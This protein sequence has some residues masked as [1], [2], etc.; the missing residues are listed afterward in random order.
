[1]YWL[2]F[3]CRLL[4]YFGSEGL[5]VNVRHR[6]E[7]RRLLALMGEQVYQIILADGRTWT[8]GAM[9]GAE[10]WLSALASVMK[11]PSF[12]DTG[13]ADLIF[14]LPPEGHQIGKEPPKWGPGGPLDKCSCE[15]SSRVCPGVVFYS[16][17]DAPH[18]VCCLTNGHGPRFP[19]EQM[20]RSLLPIF[21]GEL[22][23][24]SI[25]LHAALVEHDGKAVLLAGKSG[26]GKSTCCRRLPQGWEVLSDDMALVLRTSESYKAHP[27][28]TWS[29]VEDF[30]GRQSWSINRHVV[31]SAIFFLDQADRDEMFPLGRGEATLGIYD[32]SSICFQ[33]LSGQSNVH[34]GLPYR[35]QVFENATSLATAVPAFRLRVSL[36][37]RFWEKIEEVLATHE[38]DGRLSQAAGDV[39]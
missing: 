7:C 20:R 8:L 39:G 37:G 32:A 29:A 16:H 18:V 21:E 17:P 31:L 19:M 2:R 33:T 38:Q 9:M 25:P 14:A 24:G 26:V 5:R 30:R 6:I 27:V 12:P 1:L 22:G 23:A 34:K 10:N 4:L 13:P 15:W 36:T 11:L 35:K 3:G 28:P